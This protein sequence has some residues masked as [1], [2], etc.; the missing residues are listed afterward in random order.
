MKK[1]KVR[2]NF[3]SYKK[4]M[5]EIINESAKSVC[6]TMDFYESDGESVKLEEY[7]MILK[8]IRTSEEAMA[9]L[10]LNLR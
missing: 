1:T 9:V 5:A 2:N 8:T 6:T 4:K 7:K 3:V 10:R